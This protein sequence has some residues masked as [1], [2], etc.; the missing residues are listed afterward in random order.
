[1]TA[2]TEA[3]TADG[4]GTGE[5]QPRPEPCVPR[6]PPPGRRP[7]RRSTSSSGSSSCCGPSPPSG[8]SSTP[9][10]SRAPSGAAGWWTVVRPRLRV[11][12]LDARQLP[13]RARRGLP[14][15]LRQHARRH[16]PRRRDPHHDRRASRRTRSRGWTSPAATCSSS[17]WSGSWSCPSR[18]RSSRS[19][20]VYTDFDITGTYPAVWLAHAGFGLPLAIYLLRNYMGSLPSS[21]IE[22]ARI[23]GADHF[24]IFVRLILPLSVPVLASFAIFQFLWTWN[25]YLVAFI[26]LGIEPDVRVLTV[27]LASLSGRGRGR[28]EPDAG[29]GVRD[30]DPA[31]RRVLRAAALLRP[32]PHRRLRQGVR[33][34]L[35]VERTP[36]EALRRRNWLAIALATVVMMFSYFAYAGAFAGTE[37]EPDAR[38]TRVR[39]PRPGAGTVRVRR[40]GLRLAEPEGAGRRARRHGAAPGRRAC[41]SACW[42]PC[43]ARPPASR[44]AAWSTLNRPARSTAWSAGAWRAAAV[45]VVYTLVLLVVATPAG[46][47]TGGLLPLLMLGFADEYSVW[48]AGQED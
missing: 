19:C 29:G 39:P 21:M 27:E 38:P 35:A 1:M 18:W 45:S 26:F 8:S 31:A 14:Q 40:P 23:D 16:H 13:R 15:R 4:A 17:S 44:P 30:D 46:V 2:T 25:D 37:S 3:P 10:G 22:S 41:R 47:F 7:V 5:P 43:S 24:A 12:H 20:R 6:S 32:G 9:S 36:S 11:G 33:V 42:R 34:R 48:R 28:A